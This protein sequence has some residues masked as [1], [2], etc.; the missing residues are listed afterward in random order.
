MLR[1]PPNYLKL[2]VESVLSGHPLKS[3]T[4]F[5]VNYATS[6]THL[7][8]AIEVFLA[9]ALCS[10]VCLCVFVCSCV[11]DTAQSRWQ[12]EESGGVYKK[13][14]ASPVSEN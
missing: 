3:L 5:P 10:C 4:A 2:Y 12:A 11:C 1:I 6:S 14:P 9:S 13:L 8:E 7:S